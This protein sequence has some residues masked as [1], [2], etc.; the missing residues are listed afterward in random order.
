MQAAASGSEAMEGWHARA[1]SL[2]DGASCAGSPDAVE[3]RVLHAWGMP[4]SP[5]L[6]VEHEGKHTWPS[7][8]VLGPCSG[9]L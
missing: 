5:H 1:L 4:A 7:R 6:A 9:L 8:T 3:A 2:D